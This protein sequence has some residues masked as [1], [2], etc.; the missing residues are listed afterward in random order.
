MNRFSS[1]PNDPPEVRFGESV[2][3]YQ[4]H[5]PY[6]GNLALTYVEP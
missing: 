1:N 2:I 6:W 4:N 3:Q 5:C